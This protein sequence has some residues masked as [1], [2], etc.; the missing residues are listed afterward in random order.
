MYCRFSL[1]G[2]ATRRGFRSPH[3]IVIHQLH[4]SAVLVGDGIRRA[5][6]IGMNV[7]RDGRT[8]RCT[9]VEFL[10][11]GR[12]QRIAIP[13]VIGGSGIR[14]AAALVLVSE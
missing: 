13:D 9:V 12:E 3:L 7:P 5:E 14:I 1:V 4:Q 11:D 10:V 2:V 8:G 6:V